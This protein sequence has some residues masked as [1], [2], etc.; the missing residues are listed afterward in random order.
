MNIVYLAASSDISGG[1]RVIFQQAEELANRGCRVTIVCTH[2]PPT[3][4]P[5]EKT[6]WEMSSAAQSR[7]LAEA[8]ICVATYWTTV[9]PATRHFSGPVFH[10]CQGYEADFSFNALQLRDIETAYA[11][12][13]HKLAVSPH[14]AARLATA[15]YGPV[16][17]VGQ[18]FDPEE[19][20]APR[21]KSFNLNP[22]TVLVVGIFEAEV[23]GIQEAIPAMAALRS[24]GVRFRFHRISTLPLS[25]EEKAIF[26]ADV[27]RTRLSSS[28]MAQAYQN[29]DL[30]I[31]PSHPEEGFGLPV[32]EALSSG[33]PLLLSDTPGHR[34]IADT[35]AEYFPCGDV[36]ALARSTRSLLKNSALRAELSSKGPQQAARFRTADV[37]DRLLTAFIRALR[38]RH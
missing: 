26:R 1:Q 2:T 27:Y 3:W 30:F 22:P 11:Q 12:P 4:F 10:L 24:W 16:T 34:H 38:N 6:H 35:A 17:F 33:L 28:Q 14:V 20:P 29:A 32:L 31:G 21:K 19:F 37:A 25:E 36:H 8:D 13:T 15:G 18:T 5:L 9:L 7:A 23:K